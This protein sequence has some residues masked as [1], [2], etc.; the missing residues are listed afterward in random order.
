MNNSSEDSRTAH[1]ANAQIGADSLF[2]HLPTIQ[3]DEEVMICNPGNEYTL[4][5]LIVAL[6]RYT[7]RRT[8]MSRTRICPLRQGEETNSRKASR[9]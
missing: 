4:Q 1:V 3:E 2:P 6:H 9:V 5:L 7:P 8:K